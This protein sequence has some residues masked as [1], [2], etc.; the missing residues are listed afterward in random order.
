MASCAQELL[1][2]GVS[3]QNDMQGLKEQVCP[4]TKNEVWLECL[5]YRIGD[6][7]NDQMVEL[8]FTLKEACNPSEAYET[9]FIKCAN[10]VQTGIGK[11]GALEPNDFADCSVRQKLIKC[12]AHELTS[13]HPVVARQAKLV[14]VTSANTQ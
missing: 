2:K 9:V 4:M 8:V 13:E 10:Q 7:P 1:K 11:S 14:K 6:G 3:L 5:E 12:I